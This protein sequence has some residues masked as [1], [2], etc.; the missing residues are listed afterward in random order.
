MG[1]VVSH[2]QVQC[3]VC[4]VG[5]R[6]REGGSAI[7]RSAQQ[8]K[9]RPYESKAVR[10]LQMTG[11]WLLPTEIRVVSSAYGQ[12]ETKFGTMPGPAL[13]YDGVFDTNNE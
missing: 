8:A 10:R 6:S 3:S 7:A 4:G 9:K 5:A 2:V 12:V 11:W 1:A 13:C